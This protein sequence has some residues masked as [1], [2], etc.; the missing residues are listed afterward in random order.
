MSKPLSARAFDAMVAPPPASTLAI[1][2]L[3]GCKAIA[4]F[5]GLSEDTIHRLEKRDPTFP[6]RRRGGRMFVTKSEL[7]IWLQPR[8]DEL[9]ASI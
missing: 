9:A 5:M 6:V 8:R 7:V 4:R 3:W 2:S 1:E